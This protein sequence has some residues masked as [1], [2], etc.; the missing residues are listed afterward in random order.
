MFNK[1]FV[2]L[3]RHREKQMTGFLFALASFRNFVQI[4]DLKVTKYL[5][6]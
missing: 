1:K 5:F 4:I 3:L 6:E 2:L